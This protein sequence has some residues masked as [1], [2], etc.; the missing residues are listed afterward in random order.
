MV[1]RAIADKLSISLKQ[2][3]VIENRAGAGGNIGTDVVAKAAP[4]G[5]TLGLAVNTTL[6]ANPNLYKTSAFRFRQ[7]HRTHF[8]RWDGRSNS[9]RA[10]VRPR[11]LRDRI[12]R[13]R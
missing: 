1:A 9:D 10:S 6:T 13:I 3:F 8:D 5:Y 2:P 11:P 7:G 12:R 4:D